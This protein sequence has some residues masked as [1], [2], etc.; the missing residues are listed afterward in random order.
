MDEYAR[1]GI[2]PKSS[3]KGST[4]GH[5]LLK[6]SVQNNN[7]KRSVFQPMIRENWQLVT[8]EPVEFEK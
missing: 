6:E 7:N 8:D 1:H 4:L 2:Q 3:T 5:P